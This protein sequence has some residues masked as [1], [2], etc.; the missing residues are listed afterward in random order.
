[1]LTPIKGI[2]MGTSNIGERSIDKSALEREWAE[3]EAR[4]KLEPEDRETWNRL[5]FVIR[6]F[7]YFDKILIAWSYQDGL[8]VIKDIF[9]VLYMDGSFQGG[10]WVRIKSKTTGVES[11]LRHQ[12]Q[13]LAPGLDIFAWLP[14]FNEVRFVSANWNNPTLSRAARLSAC[15][16]MVGDPRREALLSGRD[17]LSELHVFREQ[18]PQYSQTRF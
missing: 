17:Y 5:G 7:V 16:R 1:M 11:V 6:P 9:T 2:Y 12:P 18:F 3:D 14:F 8:P 15:F 13:R 10:L 4:L